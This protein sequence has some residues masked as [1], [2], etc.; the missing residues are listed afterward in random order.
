MTG[1]NFATT[2][3]KVSFIMASS[4]APKVPGLR[5]GR[6]LDSASWAKHKRFDQNDQAF[7]LFCGL[8]SNHGI[9][10]SDKQFSVMIQNEL[11]VKVSRATIHRWRQKVSMAENLLN[12]VPQDGSDEGKDSEDTKLTSETSSNRIRSKE[13]ELETITDGNTVSE[14][15]KTAT[16]KPSE[17]GG[18]RSHEDRK[19]SNGETKTNA[20]NAQDI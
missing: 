2:R 13:G 18:E 15:V 10:W 19:C 1:D 4:T 20:A 6:R 8:Y 17:K 3:L 9:Q 11:G 16:L 14:T 12:L 7:R 5:P